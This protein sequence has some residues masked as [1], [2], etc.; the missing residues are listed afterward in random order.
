MFCI[1]FSFS[2]FLCFFTLFY[3]YFYNQS[4]DIVIVVSNSMKFCFFHRIQRNC[5]LF[6]HIKCSNHILNVA[7]LILFSDIRILILKNHKTL[8]WNTIISNYLC[9]TQHSDWI[10]KCG[11]IDLTWNQVKTVHQINM[12]LLSI[13]LIEL[14]VDEHL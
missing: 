8:A 4:L 6:S 7:H 9:E 10:K 1:L 2:V 12:N 5:V 11:S 13:E 3:V 14:Y